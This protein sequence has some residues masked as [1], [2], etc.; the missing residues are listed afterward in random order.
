M[1]ELIIKFL[2]KWQ[3]LIGSILGGIFALLVALIV[4][5]AIRRREEISSGML[6][7]GDLANIRIAYE[8]LTDLAKRQNI[9]EDDYPFWFAEKLTVSFPRLSPLFE[10]SVIRMM[11]VS[12]YLAAHLT[13][14]QKIYASVEMMAERLSED[15]K[16]IRQGNSA[17][18]KDQ[19]KADANLIHKH[20]PFAVQHASCA[21]R[22]ISDLILSKVPTWHRL[23]QFVRLR[24]DE[25]KCLKYLREGSS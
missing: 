17:R 1:D 6:L 24:A 5:H 16:S 14:F 3:T 19:L 21:E 7:I 15:F 25:K 2:Y 11:P 22:L 9:S 23:R 13:L 20:F 10:A 8:T 4:G 18:S 12:S